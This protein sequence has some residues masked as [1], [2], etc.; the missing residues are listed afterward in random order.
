MDAV[1]TKISDLQ[2]FP[3]DQIYILKI[4][5]PVSRWK[6]RSPRLVDAQHKGSA[7]LKTVLE[8]TGPQAS[9]EETVPG[10]FTDLM[11]S[12]K[13]QG[14]GR[15]LEEY[16]YVIPLQISD[17]VGDWF[18]RDVT[19]KIQ[20]FVM[21]PVVPERYRVGKWTTFSSSDILLILCCS[22]RTQGKP[23]E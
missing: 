12:L 4:K 10:T 7:Q 22:R 16:D 5:H 3:E 14:L 20:A 17:T 1:K 21:Y 8:E 6:R 15:R 13:A 18:D 9:P 23:L 19:D 11:E 2:A